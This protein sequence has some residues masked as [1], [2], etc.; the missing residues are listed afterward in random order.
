MNEESS[1]KEPTPQEE[2]RRGQHWIFAAITLLVAVGAFVYLS[3]DRT[4][5]NSGAT[6]DVC[7]SIEMGTATPRFAPKIV[8]DEETGRQFVSNSIIVGFS[9]GVAVADICELIRNQNGR[10]MQRFTNVPLFLIE[11]PDEGDGEV[12]RRTVRRFRESDIVDDAMLN[13]L[14]VLQRATSTE[15]A[16]GD[17]GAREG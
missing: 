16:F 2:E 3:R 15:D 7:S 5:A 11:V 6:I 13:Y 12:A 14:D 10:V 17:V 1:V 4:D 8:T 9:K